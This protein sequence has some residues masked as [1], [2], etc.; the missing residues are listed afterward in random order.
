MPTPGETREELL[1]QLSEIRAKLEHLDLRESGQASV[2]LRQGADS[3]DEDLS[4][5]GGD[6]MHDRGYTILG[7]IEWDSR[8]TVSRWSPEAEKAFGWKAD[9]VIGKTWDEFRFV[10]EDDLERVRLAGRDLSEGL[11]DFNT[12]LNRNYRKDGT[13]LNV[14]WFNCVRRNEEGQPALWISLAHDVTPRIRAADQVRLAR[15]AMRMV[16][17]ATARATGTEFFESLVRYISES[18]GFRHVY[19]AR[20]IDGCSTHARTI[21][22]WTDGH[23]ADEMV[24][25]LA[26]TPCENVFDRMMCFY[27][28]H[29]QELFLDDEKLARFHA[30]SYLGIP[31]T[32][33][34]GE[35]LGILAIL[36]DKPMDDRPDIREVIE[37]FADRTAL[38]IERTIHESARHVS[39]TRLRVL[40]EQMPAVLWTT[41]RELRFTHITGGA[42]RRL[43]RDPTDVIGK[44]LYERL[45]TNDP[46][47]RPIAIHLD[48]LNGVSGTSELEVSGRFFKFYV[49]PLR[50]NENEI[51]GTIGVAQDVSDLKKVEQSLVASEE[52]F[53]RLVEYAPEAVVLLDTESGH[54]M[55]VNQAA[56]KLY[57]LPAEELCKVG[58][59]DVSPPLQI[60]GRPSA[61]SAREVIGKAS[62]GE[63]QVFEWIHRDA[64]GREFPCEVRLLSLEESGGTVLRGSLT[65]LTDKKRAE[66][67]LKRLESDLAHV[68]RVSTMGEMVGGLAHELNQPLY[69]IQNFGKACGNLVA[70]D[71]D[72]NRDQLREWLDKI[73]ST[74]QYAGDILLRLRE[75]VSREPI[76]KSIVDLGQTIATALMLTKHDAQA[77]GIRVEYLP[78]AKLEPVIADTVQI[79]Q[80]LVNLLRNAFDATQEKST[81]DPIVR[82]TTE[83]INDS[84]AVTVTDNGP[85]LP[86]NPAHIF[87]A[88]SSTKTSGLGLGLAVAKT[89]IQAHGGT[90]SA[91]NGESCGAEFR[92]TLPVMQSASPRES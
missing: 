64:D 44:T 10:H 43:L 69:A 63:N 68:A 52:R 65:D 24:F 46:G 87:D 39:E 47:F 38:E 89:I 60:D 35:V 31:L 6:Q 67:S 71:G 27:C 37:L 83:M 84:V 41:D 73:T 76:K 22:F 50:D 90:L 36:D 42:L 59:I 66:E 92:F 56:E 9:E 78:H 45:Q 18:L 4:A 82:I 55:M 14:E 3:S 54:F 48:A 85:G 16:I 33:S 51:V 25:P 5:L 2:P 28:D 21:A 34:S 74:A 61:E 1:K 11:V 77:A 17:G 12:C 57:K 19:V 88:F 32:S 23:L 91:K 13:V 58:P 62:A 26:G 72:F 49:E 7:M 30:R 79:Q 29:I 40:T 8:F 80:V 75:F 53:R 81:G 15:N 70:E 86:P 20:K